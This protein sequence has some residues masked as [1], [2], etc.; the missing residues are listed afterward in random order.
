MAKRKSSRLTDLAIRQIGD[1]T[2]SDGNG[3]ALK[4]DKGG[5]HKSW[6]WRGTVGGKRVMR[7]LGSYP[8]VSLAD[9]RQ[10]AQSLKQGSK[11][12]KAVSVRASAA[13]ITAPP[14]TME[15]LPTFREL[16]LDHIAFR[17]PAWRNKRESGIW[18]ARFE[19]HVFPT[20]GD[21]RVDEITAAD[22][23]TVLRPIWH[24]KPET[25]TKIK[26]QTQSVFDYAVA[27]QH[28]PDNPVRAI[29]G[30]LPRRP[31]Q[32]KNHLALHYSDVPGALRQIKE[33]TSR[34]LTKAAFE[35]LVL[36]ASR[37]E[38]VRGATWAEMDLEN[39]I[40]HI[41]GHRMKAGR[42]HRVPLSGKAV[43]ILEDA[44][45]L[46]GGN[47]D[48]NALVFPAPRGGQLTDMAMLQ[49]LRRLEIPSTVHGMRAA[50]RSWAMET[51]AAPYDVC[52]RALS[53]RIGGSEVEAY[54]RSD[55][56]DQRRPVMESWADFCVG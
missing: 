51:G 40:W 41:P 17:A 49:V 33:S 56:L 45:Q 22:V 3:L 34:D 55:L 32:Q 52:E 16:A 12:F 21:R 7:G 36:C 37:S 14:Q 10:A 35:F 38:E 15:R 29:A 20:F 47:P 25:A 27:L 24:S 19:N 44:R 48:T 11:P 6:V 50:F 53:H 23:L 5:I 30:A 54:T 9:A 13:I 46:A 42:D 8:T 4:V 1:G 43:E 39:L 31:R 2:H 28:R 18:T 26:M